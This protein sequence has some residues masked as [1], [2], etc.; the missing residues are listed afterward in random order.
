MS[1]RRWKAKQRRREETKPENSVWVPYTI[2]N[3]GDPEIEPAMDGSMIQMDPV[4]A[5]D[6]MDLVTL[7]PYVNQYGQTPQASDLLD[8]SQ[9]GKIRRFQGDIWVTQVRHAFETE[10]STF[11]NLDVLIAWSWTLVDTGPQGSSGYTTAQQSMMH[12]DGE[13]VA[14]M[15]RRD[16]LSW[17][18]K[19]LHKGLAGASNTASD[20]EFEASQYLKPVRI[21]FPRLPKEGLRIDRNRLLRLSVSARN[22]PPLGSAS[23]A[24]WTMGPMLSLPQN[25]LYG[26][27]AFRY[28]LTV[29]S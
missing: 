18:T 21:P 14:F 19:W 23:V 13:S 11:S 2:W 20:G 27:P 1:A 17:G 12:V 8:A 25:Q 22:L 5:G 16:L 10:A 28:L 4:T 26:I 7:S 24:P 9:S 3:P 15:Q 6:G 29:D